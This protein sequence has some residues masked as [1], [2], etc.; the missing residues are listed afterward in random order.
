MD[1]NDLLKNNNL[2]RIREQHRVNR[3]TLAAV[4]Q[5]GS[6][7]IKK[8]ERGDLVPQYF[9]MHAI[10]RFF[11]LPIEEVYPNIAELNKRVDTLRNMFIKDPK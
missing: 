6:A 1:Y 8:Y 10:L 9:I 4:I 3:R 2:K 11:N 5:R 7:Q